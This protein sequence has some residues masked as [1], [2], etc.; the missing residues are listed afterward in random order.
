ME[1]YHRDFLLDISAVANCFEGFGHHPL[2]YI[3]NMMKPRVNTYHTLLG[4]FAGSALDD[5]I[6]HTDYHIADTFRNNFREKALEYVTCEDFDANRFKQDAQRQAAHIQAV[7]KNVWG[8]ETRVLPLLEPS[9]V[10]PQLGL[11]GRVDLM[12]DDFRLLVEQK[13]GK[14]IC[15][16][17]HYVQ[18]LLY[19][20]VLATNFGIDTKDIDIQLLYSK[21]PLPD[22]LRHI[23]ADR[24]RKLTD[25]ALRFRDEVV[26]LL[27][28]IA[29]DGFGSIMDQL[30][31]ETLAGD[32]MGDTFFQ[33]YELP[34]L[35]ALLQPL[36]E[37]SSMERAYFEQMMTFV[38]REMIVAKTGETVWEEER[39]GKGTG[40][41]ERKG[42]RG[43]MMQTCNADLWRMPLAEKREMGCIFTGLTISD[44]RKSSTYN[45]YDTLVFDLPDQG[46]DFMPDFRRGDMVY[47][48]AYGKDE[49][50]D[51]TRAILYKGVLADIY[52][53]SVTVHLNDGQQKAEA[54]GKTLYAIE[55]AGSDVT[56]HA[57]IAG[58]HAFITADDDRKALLLGQRAPRKDGNI[59][60]SRSYHPDYDG[61][62]ERVFQSEDYFLLVGPPGTGKTSMALRLMVEEA[63]A[64]VAAPAEGSRKASLLLLAYT[65]RAVDEICN[66]LEETGYDYLRLGN[67]YS[68]DPRYRNRLLGAYVEQAPA[69]HALR[70]TIIDMPIIVA[71]TST[72]ATRPF[73]LGIK[74]FDMAIID[75][76]SQILE[77]DIIG[78]LSN[79]H[80][81]RF[82]LI[83]DYK[84]LPA[85]VQQPEASS[86]VSNKM[87][88]SIH[89][90]NCR[91]SLFE[92]LI[93]TEKAAKRTDFIGILHKQGRMHPDIAA[94]PVNTFYAE[95]QLSA[96]P[97][98]HQQERQLDY[99]V[100]SLDET[101]DLLKSRRVLFF[102]SPPREKN[103]TEHLSDK[104]NTAEARIVAD[105]LHR[106]HRFLGKKFDAQKSMGVIVPYRNQI[107]VIRKEAARYG[108]AALNDITIDTV[109]RYQGSQRDIIIYSFTVSKPYQLDF[110]TSNC[111]VEN[112]KVIDRKL[113]VALTRARKQLILVGNKETLSLNPT[114]K[115]LLTEIGNG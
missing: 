27:Y 28:K 86:A 82:V 3:V 95:E 71:T 73:L 93:R 10:C 96:V 22:G 78:L 84:Q 68:C 114:F 53:D 112:G 97:L 29:Q 55:H 14:N 7:V 6:N 70:K 5:I 38:V 17:K 92:R 109:E 83:G 42:A 74:S 24:N 99:D 98:R 111:F 52:P 35:Q 40:E 25:E 101:D 20:D 87:L 43:V 50:P 36:H 56:R 54:F 4:N 30:T 102:P 81:R 41:E 76:A 75:E 18:A 110:L 45:G 34:R 48:Y 60:L 77:P 100:E 23:D 64:T 94:F 72:L 32:S 8:Q 80:I 39:K 107:A 66:M 31:P 113:N 79:S 85:V 88:R 103:T 49:Q 33:R 90:D 104:V 69:V 51:I 89:L 26:T 11:Q 115:K 59:R 16:Q 2:L 15:P 19:Y 37:L 1:I 63:M 13:S 91:N 9:F 65:N 47:V 44:M 106:L 46:E 108:I 67:E 12:T 57:A 62:V 21:F 105:L 58:L 61:V